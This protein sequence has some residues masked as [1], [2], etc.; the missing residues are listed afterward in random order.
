[1]NAI[2]YKNNDIPVGKYLNTE[3]YF[4]IKCG[5]K[6]KEIR[7]IYEYNYIKCNWC[8]SESLNDLSQLVEKQSK[9][10]LWG[11]WALIKIKRWMSS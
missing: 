4:S 8:W 7:R 5:N 6:I 3:I 1:M 2:N 11:G 10:L 9:Y